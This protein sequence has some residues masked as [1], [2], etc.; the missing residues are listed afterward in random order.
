[1]ALAGGILKVAVGHSVDLGG[2]GSGAGEEL[3][4]W[5]RTFW[6]LAEITFTEK[7][8]DISDRRNT[9]VKAETYGRA[10][11]VREGARTVCGGKGPEGV[12]GPN[13]GPVLMLHRWGHLR[14]LKYVNGDQCYRSW[15]DCVCFLLIRQIG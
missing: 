7:G 13:K 2:G 5:R 1:M 6:R 4:S 14:D 8:K 11:C 10:W 15:I 9:V 12:C 3:F